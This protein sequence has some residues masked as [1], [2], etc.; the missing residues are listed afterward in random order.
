MHKSINTC[1]LMF[2]TIMN[3]MYMYDVH[4]HWFVCNAPSLAMVFVWF[5][6]R[7]V[8]HNTLTKLFADLEM[9][10]KK[11]EERDQAERSVVVHVLN[12]L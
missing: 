4:V 5:Q 11:L 8:L 1:M 2:C 10:K 6:Y 3:V 12:I 9:K 7:Q